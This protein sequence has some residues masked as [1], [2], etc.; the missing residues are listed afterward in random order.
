[1]IVS[2]TNRALSQIGVGEAIGVLVG[3]VV[4]V[5]VSVEVV[6]MSVVGA[7]PSAVRVCAAIVPTT[8]DVGACVPADC[9]LQ[10]KIEIMRK[11]IGKRKRLFLTI[12]APQKNVIL[13]H[14]CLNYIPPFY[15]RCQTQS[16]RMTMSNNQFTVVIYS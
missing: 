6:V 2:E 15:P 14:N 10:A 8:S 5:G 11:A 1:M 9:A 7:P 13:H 16:M 4:V 3:M 12:V